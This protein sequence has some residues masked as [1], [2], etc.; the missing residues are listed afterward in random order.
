[1]MDLIREVQSSGTVYRLGWTLL[2]TLWIGAAL[3]GLLAVALA[4]LR[5]RSANARYLAACAALAL[6][7][8]SPVATFMVVPAPVRPAAAELPGPVVAEFPDA[9]VPLGPLPVIGH[10]APAPESVP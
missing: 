2:H 7:A 6:L 9:S 8:L 1:M 5:R 10:A 4:V 3:V